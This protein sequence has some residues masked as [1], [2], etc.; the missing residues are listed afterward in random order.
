MNLYEEY[1]RKMRRI[2]DIEHAVAILHWDK[3]VNLP[4]GASYFRSQQIATLSSMAHEQF[5]DDS[6]GILL[7][8]L[9]SSSDLDADHKR[10]VELSLRD[11]HK[12][13][14]LPTSFVERLSMAQ[15]EAFTAW[16]VARDANDFSAFAPA[17]EHLVFLKREE[18]DLRGY[19]NERYDALLDIYE[20]GLTVVEVDRLFDEARDRIIPLIRKIRAGTQADTSFLHEHY[21]REMQWQFGLEVIRQ[22][23]YNFDWGRQDI[24]THPFTISFSPQDVRITTRIDENDF[25]NMLWSC[26][27]ECGHALYEQGLPVHQYGLPLGSPA[28]LAI[29]ESQSRLW[30]NQVARSKVFWHYQ[31]PRLKAVFPENLT[32]ISLDHFHAAIN[33][34]AP[35]LIRTEADELHYHLHVIIR[36][37]IER[38][39]VNTDLSVNTLQDLWNQKYREYLQVDVPDDRKGI[40]QDVHWSHGSFGYFPTYSMGSF[41]AA[42]FYQKAEQDIPDLPH[43][44]AEGRYTSLHAWLRENVYA[45]GRRWDP[46]DLC[47]SITG[48]PLG[49]DHFITYVKHKYAILADG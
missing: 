28:S 11:Y 35:N 6:T 42:Q 49:I 36:Y 32:D 7:D 17:F 9:M 40:L 15:S 10:N 23:G 34:I 33:H 39:L 47:R 48:L 16:I 29:H 12:A 30:E 13:V 37:E 1:V 24:S 8:R 25:S 20:P 14:M 4:K 41:Y 43:E 3:E 31:L 44:I 21:P 46:E 2:A 45:H 26:I 18:A 5:I 22:L 19:V 38:E 27:H